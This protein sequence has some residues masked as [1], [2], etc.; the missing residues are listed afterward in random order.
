MHGQ[1]A[2]TTF[3]YGLPTL[4]VAPKSEH[5]KG[6]P[7]YDLTLPNDSADMLAMLVAE[8]YTKPR[9]CLLDDTIHL[10][11]DLQSVPGYVLRSPT[12]LPLVQH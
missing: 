9:S 7:K 2:A 11:A 12:A 3:D 4:S 6:I 10:F 1:K 8:V 5:W